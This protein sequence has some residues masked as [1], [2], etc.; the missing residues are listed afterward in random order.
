LDEITLENLLRSEIAQRWEEGYEVT[1]AEDSLQKIIN[2]PEKEK[3]L[4]L[5]A[6]WDELET[7]QPARARAN[8]PFIEPTL[9]ENIQKERIKGPR[10]LENQ[11]TDEEYNNKVRGAWL[12]RCIGCLLGKPVEGW[13]KDSIE[14]YLK[15]SDSYPLDYYI[16]EIIPHPE[17]YSL[18]PSYKEAVRGKINGMP[19]DDDIDY[20]ILGLHIIEEYGFN[21]TS[22]DIA[23]EW[24]GHLPYHLVYTGERVAYKNIVNGIMPPKSAY[25]R[26]PYREWIGAQIRADI[27]GYIVPGYPEIAAKL[28]YRDA[29]ISHVKNGVYGEMF[30]AAM[31][32][33][34]FVNNNIKEIIRIGISEIPRWSRLADAARNT[35]L[36]SEMH[37][38]WETAWEK[39]IWAYSDYS[40]L[41]TINNACLV[42][43]GLLYGDGELGKSISI[44]VMGGL[45]SDCNGATTGSIIGAILGSQA[46]PEKWVSPLNDSVRS[47]VAGFS[48]SKIS[49]LSRITSEISKKITSQ[50]FKTK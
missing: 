31:I 27:W 38:D 32:S 22:N 48:H 44:S 43:L 2:G 20:T 47:V 40:W 19:R 35:I 16:P 26:N 49:E 29:T 24:L 9:L 21:V 23:S 5:M 7:S 17:G 36:W 1:K 6:L 14:K 18:H 46:L 45:D 25:Y 8:F 10:V 4:K 11:L 42:L 50:L 15:M 41:H 37:D 33:A 30:I 12:G 28:A 34:A 13:S 39:I 3:N